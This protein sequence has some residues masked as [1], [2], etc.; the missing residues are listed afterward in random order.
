METTIFGKCAAYF[1]EKK[2]WKEA[3]M[4]LI[5]DFYIQF[6]RCGHLLNHW[7]SPSID[8][9][10]KIDTWNIQLLM[11]QWFLTYSVYLSGL[12]AL[13]STYVIYVNIYRMA[14]VCLIVNILWQSLIEKS[15]GSHKFFRGLK[16]QGNCQVVNVICSSV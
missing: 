14:R 8:L 7:I 11:K 9:T 2:A 1:V 4:A 5:Y 12:S 3:Y 10:K 6:S 15:C 13:I 16:A